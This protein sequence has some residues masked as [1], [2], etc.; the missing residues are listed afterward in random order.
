M[1]RQGAFILVTLL[2]LAGASVG[3][4]RPGPFV[5]AYDLQGPDAAPLAAAI[6]LNTLYLPVPADFAQHPFALRKQMAEA[7]RLGL[8]VILALPTMP[9][10]P[11]GITATDPELA[12]YARA[13][14]GETVVALRDEP[15]LAGWATADYLEEDLRHTDEEFAEFLRERYGSLEL[16]NASWRS[17]FTNW[18]DISMAQAE[19]LDEQ[20]PF[21]VGR[22]SVDL[23]DY[24]R[25]MFMRVMELWGHQVR[26]LDAATPLFTG[27]IGLYRCLTAVP[28]SY[29][30][31][32]AAVSPAIMEADELCHNVHAVDMARQAGRFDV[33]RALHVPVPGEPV[34]SD[35]AL[36]QW[37]LQ[38]ALH[39]A[40][41]VGLDNYSR[42]I[43]SG[44]LPMPRPP[45]AHPTPEALVQSKLAGIVRGALERGAFTVQ[46]QAHAAFLYEPYAGGHQLGDLPVYGYIGDFSEGEPNNLFNA[47]RRG[48][49]FGGVDYLSIEVLREPSVNLDQYSFIAAPLAL[50]L[51]AEAAAR[52]RDYVTDG[53]AFLTDLGAGMYQSGS[54]QRLPDELAPLLGVEQMPLL[55]GGVM[56]KGD[57]SFGVASQHFPSIHPPLDSQGSFTVRKTVTKREGETERRVTQGSVLDLRTHTYGGWMG[58]ASLL[59][60]AVPFAIGRLEYS[61]TAGRLSSGII[62]HEYGLGLGI[63]A[64]TRLWANWS[65]GDPAFQSFHHDLWARRAAYELHGPT[66]FARD[67]E[68]CA[69]GDSLYLLNIGRELALAEFTAGQAAN[70][71]Y[72]GGFCWFSAGHRLPSGR[73]SGRVMVSAPVPPLRVA[74]VVARP[75]E[76]KPH[77]AEAAGVV[78][79]YRSDLVELEIAGA[80]ALLRG[81]PSTG[82]QLGY[83]R[84]TPVRIM[85]RPG[86]KDA[87]SIAPLSQHQVEVNYDFQPPEELSIQADHSGRL[88][89]DINARRA[90]VR[91]MPLAPQSS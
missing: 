28:D 12:E 23:A 9:P 46:P 88:R 42:L 32:V 45:T 56:E 57:F 35:D 80:G 34:Y 44:L 36:E 22:P 86:G 40:V 78:L 66:L 63:F 4:A 41:G 77:Y 53:G 16:L 90:R 89:F 3:Y 30:V 75:V 48:S 31:V 52:I 85:L 64:T 11:V 25:A 68:I 91:I 37:M 47:F 65:P 61:E 19:E 54:W 7:E 60:G 27:R 73:R 10:G 70:R 38:A 24:E 71:I 69:S 79:T 76:I 84:R 1:N 20:Q 50:S 15:A 17:G 6:G 49:R 2:L 74:R 29:D 82:W 62:L 58:Y 39:G 72:Q 26:V 81:N 59:P 18:S 43:G 51:P 21:G 5:F 14:I 55:R 87:Y 67:I 8:K 33:V 13:V 83:G